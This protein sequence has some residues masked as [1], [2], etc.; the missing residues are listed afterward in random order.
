MVKTIEFCQVMWLVMLESSKDLILVVDALGQHVSPRV[1]YETTCLLIRDIVGSVFL[2]WVESGMVI[3]PSLHGA[4][5]TV[6]QHTTLE[7]FSIAM[8]PRTTLAKTDI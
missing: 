2:G 3:H 1:Q 4:R 5:G 7:N 6:V 8:V